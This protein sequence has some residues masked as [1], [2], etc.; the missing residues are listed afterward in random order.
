[1]HPRSNQK[2]IKVTKKKKEEYIPKSFVYY[3]KYIRKFMSK[4][5]NDVTENRDTQSKSAHMKRTSAPLTC[6]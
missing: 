6:Q 4:K 5:A 2:N 3:P 1:M